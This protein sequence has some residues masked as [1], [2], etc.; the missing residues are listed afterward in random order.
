MN[1]SMGGTLLSIGTAPVF[2]NKYI[3]YQSYVH[4]YIDTEFVS[5]MCG[6]NI[7]LYIE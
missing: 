2:V 1:D 4:M 3:W 5:C 7:H 6:D